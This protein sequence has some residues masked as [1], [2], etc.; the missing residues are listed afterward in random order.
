MR[1]QIQLNLKKML[2][3]GI[4]QQP[5]KI[6]FLIL[7]LLKGEYMFYAYIQQIQKIRYIIISMCMI[8]IQHLI[9]IEII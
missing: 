5:K 9:G 7:T 4:S 8:K 6:K 3:W 1:H 2:I